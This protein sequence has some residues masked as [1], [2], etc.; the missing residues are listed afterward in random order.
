[1][2]VA[3]LSSDRLAQV[4]SCVYLFLF[5][6]NVKDRGSLQTLVESAAS[7]CHV[8]LILLSLVLEH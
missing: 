3:R 7:N 2:F 8:P 6:N 5:L 4:S 1:L